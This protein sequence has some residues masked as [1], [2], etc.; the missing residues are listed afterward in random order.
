[1]IRFLAS[2]TL[3]AC[4][5]LAFSGCSGPRTP[6]PPVDLLLVNA[7]VYTLAW[8]EPG[9][10]G[11]PDT[12]A[13]FSKAAG[14][15]PDAEAVAVRDGR[16][17]F[18]GDARA[19]ERYRAS[20]KASV[21]LAGATVVPGLIESHAHVLEL[22]AT[23]ERVDLVGVK[24]EEEAVER[25]VARAAVVPQGEW[26]VGWGWDEGAWANRYPDM[27]ALSARVPRHP[28]M[29]RGLHGF[30]VWGNRLAF[31]RAGI[32]RATV[33]PVGG[34]IRRDATG[35]PTGILI[36]RAGTLLERAVPEASPAQ[37]EAR[38]L[39]ALEALGA[40]GYVSVHEAGADAAEMTALEKLNAERRL[41]LRVYAMLSARDTALSRAWLAR[42]PNRGDGL[43]TVRAV[44]AFYDGALGSRGAR[45][46]RDYADQPGSR[47]LSGGDYGFDEALVAD[48]MKAGFQACLHAI[49]DA[50]NRETLDFIQSVEAVQ[51]GVRAGRQRIE[52]AQVVHPADLPRFAALGAIASM[53]PPHAVEDKAWATD[54]LGP[55]RVKGA[56]AWRALRQAGARLAFNSDLPGSDYSIFYGLHAAITRRDKE[57]QPPGGWYPE[58]RM[59]PE[60]AL[61]GYTTWGAYAGFQEAETGVIAPGKWADLTVMDVDPLAL[62]TTA[63]ERLLAGS[64]RMTIVGGRI[65]Y[66]AS[67]GSPR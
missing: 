28:V 20:A 56:Y 60:E 49:G 43:L 65:V 26:I 58:Q 53:E 6:E 54:R 47:G 44:K 34:E 27:A 42:G 57:A 15:R 50:G 16:I 24:T 31:D 62:G 12:A 3:V 35:N 51:P 17:V 48:M 67:G 30:A 14:W 39:K 9:V 41:P 59:T 10:D 21:D 19:A 4:G 46:L 32:T 22:G 64:I 33:A 66:R 45:L 2:W 37:I 52:H 61:R 13:P 25:V 29:L 40:A 18:A 38:L 8:P 23:L 5:V 36:N 55:D 1:M 7:R 11:T 63:P